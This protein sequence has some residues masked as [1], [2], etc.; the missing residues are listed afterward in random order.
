M[1]PAFE[2]AVCELEVLELPV[3]SVVDV[4]RVCD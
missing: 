1:L 4:P 2:A 3:V